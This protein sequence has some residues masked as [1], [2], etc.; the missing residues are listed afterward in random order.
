MGFFSRPIYVSFAL[1]NAAMRTLLILIALLIPGLGTAQSLE[2]LEKR[3][4]FKD[5]K[6]NTDVREYTGLEFKKNISEKD[7]PEATYYVA[8]KGEYTSIGDVKVLS[9]EVKAYK[10][11]IY[12]IN[13]ITEKTPDLYKGLK[14]IYGEPEFS[15]RT[16]VYYWATPNLRLS[17]IS[18]S[19]N[20]LELNYFSYLVR[21]EV[22]A[23]KAKKIDE[24]SD[25]F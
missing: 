18:H 6:L 7:F 23:D 11:L 8:K 22:K 4:G 14:Q 5:I 19:K 15:V 21:Q 13:V 25:D 24:I 1:K 17:F 12:E 16:N 20:K 9:V 3:H 10:D 2:E